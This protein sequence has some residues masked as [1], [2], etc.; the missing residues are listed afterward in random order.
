[1]KLEPNF[2]EGVTMKAV[3][4]K[5]VGCIPKNN[6]LIFQRGGKFQ[7]NLAVTTKTTA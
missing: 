7:I 1:M 3:V 4:M 5:N 2:N 6:M